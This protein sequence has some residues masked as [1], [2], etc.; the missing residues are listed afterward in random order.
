M[1]F[2]LFNDSAVIVLFPR[3]MPAQVA[4]LFQVVQ[5]L[6]VLKLVVFVGVDLSGLLGSLLMDLENFVSG[7]KAKLRCW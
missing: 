1:R 4:V 5:D 6:F 2:E 7:L 3:Y